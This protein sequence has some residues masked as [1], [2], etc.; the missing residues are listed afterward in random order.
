MAG[1]L[2]VDVYPTNW[3][4]YRM[5]RYR[6]QLS[7][8]RYR[9]NWHSLM[10]RHCAYHIKIWYRALPGTCTVFQVI[11]G[12]VDEAT[13]GNLWKLGIGILRKV[14]SGTVRYGRCVWY[15]TACSEPDGSVTSSAYRTNRGTVHCQ[16]RV[17][18]LH[19]MGKAK[20]SWRH[21][22]VY[23]RVAMNAS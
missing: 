10:H 23:C 9:N 2:Y 13:L 6:M 14:R 18:P 12:E 17:P 22:T 16:T 11:K 20:T 15:G 4:R 3:A 8:V 19:S 7:Y 21:G 5:V 1:P